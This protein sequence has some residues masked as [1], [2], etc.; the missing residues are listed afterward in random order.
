MRITII[1]S[2]RTSN[3]FRRV[4]PRVFCAFRPFWR[5]RRQIT[6]S[7]D[8]WSI[9]GPWKRRWILRERVL[10]M[11]LNDILRT[12]RET[13]NRKKRFFESNRCIGNRK[14]KKIMGAFCLRFFSL[15][16]RRI[17]K[18]KEEAPYTRFNFLISY[19]WIDYG[20]CQKNAKSSG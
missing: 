8:V 1:T 19:R 12:E 16:C 20:G 3:P 10:V 11:N 15:T 9:G 18:R 6:L 4:R 17:S 7:E 14:M 13:G 5:R 2:R